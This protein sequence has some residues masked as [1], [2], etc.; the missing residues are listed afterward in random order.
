MLVFIDRMVNVLKQLFNRINTQMQGSNL[1]SLMIQ[2]IKFGIVGVSN[3]AISYGIEM[4]FFYVILVN[5]PMSQN[6]KVIVT[7]VC[8]FIIS[9][10]NSYFWNNRFV[11][12]AEK[13]NLRAH[14]ISYFKTV[15]AYGVTGLLLSPA[16]KMVL[17]GYEMPYYWAS[18]ISLIVTIPLNFVLNKFWAFRKASAVHGK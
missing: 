4:L 3:T 12:K 18:L 2:F 1:L 8:A 9:V 5:S 7:S 17:V 6:M 16:I 14:A 13:K 11:F 15:I 10:S